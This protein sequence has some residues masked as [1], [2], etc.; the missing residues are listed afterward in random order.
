MEPAGDA[1][2]FLPAE[3]RLVSPM[4][5]RLLLE[6]M[7]AKDDRWDHVGPSAINYKTLGLYELHRP[8][9][10]EIITMLAHRVANRMATA[11]KE[12]HGTLD[13]TEVESNRHSDVTL[14]MEL[15]TDWK[16]VPWLIQINGWE[17][18][19]V[20]IRDYRTLPRNSD[21]SEITTPLDVAISVWELEA[22]VV[23]ITPKAVKTEEESWD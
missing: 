2:I 7:F 21:D 5:R 14:L 8:L 22:H 18:A 23:T 4:A 3:A 13:K 6:F 15:T 17:M 11:R 1:P 19:A 12:Y 16:N 9:A 10:I 20:S